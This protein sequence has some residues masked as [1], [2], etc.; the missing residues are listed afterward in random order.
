MNKGVSL[1]ER[2]DNIF[3]KWINAIKSIFNV[4]SKKNEVKEKN[5]E[6]DDFEYLKGIIEGRIDIKEL[7]IGL[8]RRLVVLCE[9]RLDEVNNQIEQKDK[10]IYEGKKLLA[11]IENILT[12]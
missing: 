7:D 8:K 2:K 6:L 11:Q 1:I 5:M 9:K 10:Q 4:K 12:K 3:K